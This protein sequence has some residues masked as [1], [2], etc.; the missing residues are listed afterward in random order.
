MAASHGL[1][2]DSAEQ[3]A[4]LCPAHRPHPVQTAIKAHYAENQSIAELHRPRV[5]RPGTHPSPQYAL[6]GEVGR[7]TIHLVDACDI[8]SNLQR[9]ATAHLRILDIGCGEGAF[10]AYAAEQLRIPWS[11]LL[12][13]SAE[14]GRLRRGED[15]QPIIPDSSFSI[16]NVEDEKLVRD[17]IVPRQFD[18][19]VSFSTFWHLV[20]PLGA[21]VLA[22]DLLL[23]P[24]G[25]LLVHGVPLSHLSGEMGSPTEDLECAAVLQA[26]LRRQGYRVLLL[27]QHESVEPAWIRRLTVTWIQ[28]KASGEPLTRLRLP[29]H[30]SVEG[31]RSIHGA[32][33]AV[34]SLQEALRDWTG[35]DI[36]PLMSTRLPPTTGAEEWLSRTLAQADAGLLAS[37]ATW[38]G[39]FPRPTTDDSS[40]P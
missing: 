32:P 30:Y 14:D 26:W 12:G 16:L 18:V 34:Y 25:T 37:M 31:T 6:H 8:V 40:C 36:E 21:I 7:R 10:L 23:E 27:V 28:V 39:A 22:H 15:R 20:D 24:G 4:S 9:T 33:R 19:V 13:L 1:A 17:H 29:V 2:G 11:Y 35:G 38:P 5:A 3:T